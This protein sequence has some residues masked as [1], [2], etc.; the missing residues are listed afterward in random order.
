MCG[1]K[2]FVLALTVDSLKDR[3]VSILQIC[4][5]LLLDQHPVLVLGTYSR[6]FHIVVFYLEATGKH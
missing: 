5:L 6:P 2:H 3:L 4:R 1:P